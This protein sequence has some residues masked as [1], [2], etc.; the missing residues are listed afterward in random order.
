MFFHSSDGGDVIVS[1]NAWY[2]KSS[3][4]PQPLLHSFHPASKLSV[5]LS[6]H[7]G[8]LSS[9]DSS[10]SIL[11]D[12]ACLNLITSSASFVISFFR[13]LSVLSLTAPLI[14]FPRRLSFTAFNTL[15]AN[16]SRNVVW[17]LPCRNTNHLHLR[18]ALLWGHL[19]VVD[20]ETTMPTPPKSTFFIH[21][22]NPLIGSRLIWPTSISC[23]GSRLICA[24]AC[25]ID[26]IISGGC[27]FGPPRGHLGFSNLRECMGKL[28]SRGTIPARWLVTA[29]MSVLHYWL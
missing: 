16:S 21:T 20:L 12:M 7:T 27:H 29:P 23:I 4:S 9:R 15:A 3:L 24:C 6:K 2:A 22:R 19:L 18:L 26:D 17:Q 13:S 11:F 8:A 10:L 25:D 1:I 28:W 14:I 5:N